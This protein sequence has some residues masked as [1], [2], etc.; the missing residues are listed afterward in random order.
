MTVTSM[1]HSK[2]STVPKTT[3][4]YESCCRMAVRIVDALFLT[5]LNGNL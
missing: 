4:V 3:M 1:R 2:A 5:D